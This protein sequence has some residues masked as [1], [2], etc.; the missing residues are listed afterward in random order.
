MLGWVVSAAPRSLYPRERD[1]VP[2][3]QDAWW[4]SGPVW[5]GAGNLGPPPLT[6]PQDSFP[7]PSSPSRVTVPTTLSRPQH[8]SKCLCVLTKLDG[9]TAQKPRSQR[10]LLL[11]TS[12]AVINKSVMCVC[13]LDPFYVGCQI[14]ENV[15]LGK[16]VSVIFSEFHV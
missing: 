7:G 14:A 16:E 5:T 1:P 3:A 10:S 4:F 15:A 11:R 12:G 9:I 6:H 2:V 13:E 8:S